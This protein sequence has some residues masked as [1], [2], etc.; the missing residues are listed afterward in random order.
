MEHTVLGWVLLLGTWT[1]ASTASSKNGPLD[2][3]EM[4]MA[5]NSCDDQYQG[6]VNLME[7]ELPE[8]NR[9]EFNNEDFAEGWRF[10][11]KEWQK[12]WG[13]TARQPPLCCD[14]GLALM[15]YT[16][17]M[18]LYEV[19]NRA[20]REGGR[21]QQHYL[22]SYPFKTLHFLLIRALHTLRRSQ[23]Q[24]CFQVVHFGQ[25]SSSSFNQVVAKSFGQDTFFS[26]ETCYGVPIKE[27]STFPTEDEVLIPP[28][29]QFEVTNITYDGDRRVIQLRSQGM[30]STYNCEFVKKRCKE[31]PCAFSAGKSSPWSRSPWP[32]L[33]CPGSH[34]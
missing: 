11:I 3:V 29:E 30:H 19:F 17:Q 18:D 31:R 22:S 14:Q 2:E 34:L 13:R 6:C 10:A 28:F 27:F 1:G 24:R 26:V 8:L 7:A 4:D 16:T 15:A 12:R 23:P 33:G 9:T 20:T 32:R 21:S 5:P 25:F